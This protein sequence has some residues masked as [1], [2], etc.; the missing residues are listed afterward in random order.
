MSK[1]GYKI[2]QNCQYQNHKSTLK[3][4]DQ[5]IKDP[6]IICQSVKYRPGC[7]MLGHVTSPNVLSD[8]LVIHIWT[9]TKFQVFLVSG[10]G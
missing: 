8:F 6:S 1:H 4:S 7:K 2:L 9:L 10:I 3:F 5:Y